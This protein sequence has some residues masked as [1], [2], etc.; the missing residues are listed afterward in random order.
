MPDRAIIKLLGLSIVSLFAA[1]IL[2]GCGSARA[3]RSESSTLPVPTPSAADKAVREMNGVVLVTDWDGTKVVRPEAE[4]KRLLTEFEYYVLREKGTE[5]PYS[6][7]LNANKRSGTYHCAACGLAVFSSRH[8]YNSQ[9]G[10]PSFYK[11]FDN[12]HVAEE[13]DRSIPEEVRTEV[14]C[15]RCGSHL[16]HVFDDGPEPTGLRYCINAVALKFAPAKK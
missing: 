15:A 6:G 1:T 3:V 5:E 4:W 9:T 12:M 14:L 8:K 10:W 16:G 2:F 7:K 13:V 11:A